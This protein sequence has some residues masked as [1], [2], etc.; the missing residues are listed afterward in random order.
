[1]SDVTKSKI[2]ILV[3]DSVDLGHALLACAHSS[4]SCYLMWKG[5]DSALTEDFVPV[6]VWAEKSFRKVVCKVTQEEFD[7]AKDHGLP[8]RDYR[9]MTESGCNNEEVAIVF[10]PRVEWSPF[11]KGLKLYR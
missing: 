6:E 7:R 9:V 2:Y 10:R 1:M 5:M 8:L 4:L 11:F 3:K